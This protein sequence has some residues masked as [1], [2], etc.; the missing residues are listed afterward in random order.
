MHDE[1]AGWRHYLKVGACYWGFTL[2]DGALRLLVLFH[3]F[4][5]GYTPFQLAFLFVFYELAGIFATLAGGWLATRY[6]L[7][8]MLAAGVSL[9][10]IGLLSLS[11]LQPHWMPAVSFIWVVLTQGISGI[12]K[13]L[14][15]TASKAAIKIVGVRSNDQ[16]FHWVAWFTGSKNA[17]KGVGFFVG[18]LGMAVAGFS[19][20][21][22]I[23]AGV[24]LAS[25]AT[26]PAGLG[27]RP[28]STSISE[29]FS[30]SSAVNLL[31]AAR[32]FL[33]W[34]R[35]IWFVVGI[36]IYLYQSGWHFW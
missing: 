19:L 20:S 27:Q 33:F 1:H 7:R 13:D 21:L 14:T 10:I 34:A 8:T 9:Q 6:G 5:L 11:F 24:L 4:Q 35:D 16:L 29:F 30:K 25:L 31:A 2:S 22:W 32:V 18:S 17:I 28:A 23:L 3:F 12:A 15:K 26:L 36:S